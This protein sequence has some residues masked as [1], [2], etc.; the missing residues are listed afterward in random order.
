M[1]FVPDAVLGNEDA[2]FAQALVSI[3]GE[4]RGRQVKAMSRKKQ[5]INFDPTSRSEPRYPMQKEN[6]GQTYERRVI[7][8]PRRP[9]STPRSYT[10]YL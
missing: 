1:R 3:D 8:P 7:N 2:G 6:N 9:L 5:V 10:C 4:W